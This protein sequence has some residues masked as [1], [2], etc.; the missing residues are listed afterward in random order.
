LLDAEV[1]AQD[2]RLQPGQERILLVEKSQRNCT[3]ATRDRGNAESL[4]SARPRR[5]EIGVKDAMN[6][7]AAPQGIAQR[8][9]LVT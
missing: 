1:R 6:S 7:P 4:S 9:G 3:A 2:E 8:A 5:A